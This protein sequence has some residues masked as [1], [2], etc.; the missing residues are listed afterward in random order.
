MADPKPIALSQVDA[1]DY[2]G[3][4]APQ[5]FVVVGPVPVP[6]QTVTIADIPGLQDILD[7]YET[8][9]AALEALNA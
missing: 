1:E 3:A 6:E 4:G 7:D 5:P 8:R 2:V 9:I